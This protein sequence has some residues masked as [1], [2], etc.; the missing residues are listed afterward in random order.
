MLYKLVLIFFAAA[1]GLPG[2]Y[3]KHAKSASLHAFERTTGPKCC[4][5]I[6]GTLEN[7]LETCVVQAKSIRDNGKKES[8]YAT[9]V[10]ACRR[11]REHVPP[12]ATRGL[13][14]RTFQ[15][16][17]GMQSYFKLPR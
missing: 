7:D 15:N 11:A 12:K 4:E 10:R 2:A 17:R 14:R 9:G 1:H 5:C 8:C 13:Q 3:K 6:T 16:A